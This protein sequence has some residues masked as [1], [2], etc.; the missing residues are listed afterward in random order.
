MVSRTAH[1]EQKWRSK[2]RR[3]EINSRVNP[4]EDG[5]AIIAVLPMQ[6]R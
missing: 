5:R 6:A 1:A 2:K 3:T 4:A